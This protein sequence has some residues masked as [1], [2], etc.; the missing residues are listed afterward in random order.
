MSVLIV[1]F[2][3]CRVIKVWLIFQLMLSSNQLKYRLQSFDPRFD[4]LMRTPITVD[5]TKRLKR[6]DT[7]VV[8]QRK[9]SNHTGAPGRTSC[10]YYPLDRIPDF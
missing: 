9:S 2:K 8:K 3:Y 5:V 6:E 10:L 7:P 1:V 4:A